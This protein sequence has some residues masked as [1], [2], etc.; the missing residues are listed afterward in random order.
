M[1]IWPTLP[2]A[3]QVVGTENIS[4]GLEQGSRYF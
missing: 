3:N 4:G 2:S 1:P